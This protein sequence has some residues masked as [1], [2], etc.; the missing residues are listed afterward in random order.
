MLAAPIGVFNSS[1]PNQFDFYKGISISIKESKDF[2][3]TVRKI[4]TRLLEKERVL[5]LNSLALKNEGKKPLAK[6]KVAMAIVH[7]IMENLFALAFVYNHRLYKGTPD[8]MALAIVTNFIEAA[9]ATFKAMFPIYL[10]TGDDG[11]PKVAEM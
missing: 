11:K 5:E 10:E 7:E 2:E 9:I 3:P 4:Y 1:V 6:D 8:I